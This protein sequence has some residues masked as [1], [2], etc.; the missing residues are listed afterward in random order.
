MDESCQAE[1]N[2]SYQAKENWGRW[3]EI[4]GKIKMKDEKKI[5][6]RYRKVSHLYLQNTH[7]CIE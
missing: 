5:E 6:D 3:A 7:I 4:D 2:W 1:K